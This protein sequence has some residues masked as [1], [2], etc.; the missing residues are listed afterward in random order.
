[1]GSSGWILGPTGPVQSAPTSSKPFVWYANEKVVN[2]Q[3]GYERRPDGIGGVWCHPC[4]SGLFSPGGVNP[5]CSVCPIG[6]VSGVGASECVNL[7]ELTNMKA[8]LAA[9]KNMMTN[10]RKYLC[11]AA[12]D[13]CG[14]GTKWIDGNCVSSYDGMKEACI[15][16]RPGWE[17]TC[18]SLSH[19]CHTDR[20][21]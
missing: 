13:F 18:E 16:A 6:T 21:A 20:N 7:N 11:E 3:P 14:P 5:T 10:P 1:M 17:W 2:C 8:E 9:L 15:K 19:S 12:T 4:A